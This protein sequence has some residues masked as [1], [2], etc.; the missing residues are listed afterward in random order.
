MTKNR[1]PFSD[2]EYICNIQK[3]NGLDLGTDHLNRNSC[4]EFVESISSSLHDTLVSKLKQAK[5]YSEMSDS[6]TDSFIVDQERPC[7]IC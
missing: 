5:F 1:K 4:V 3:K 2:Y 6:S 7:S